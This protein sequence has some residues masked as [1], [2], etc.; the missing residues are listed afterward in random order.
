MSGEQDERDVDRE[1]RR[2][3]RLRL[4]VAEIALTPAANEEGDHEPDPKEAA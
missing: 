1:G 3:E 2:L 4:V